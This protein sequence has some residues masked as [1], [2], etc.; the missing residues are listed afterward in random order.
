MS[1]RRRIV[2]T[3][4]LSKESIEWLRVRADVVQCGSSDAGFAAAL[5]SAHGLIVRTYTHVDEAMLSG[6]PYLRVV[7]R[8]G[9]G[10]DNIDV[11]ACGRRSIAV[12]NTP[13]AN[14]QAVV[15]YVTSLVTS[16]LRPQ[17]P[18]VTSALST[19]EWSSA[20][21]AA[22]APRQMSECS[23]GILGLGHIGQRIA[24][25][26]QAIG[27]NTR[28]CDVADIPE[29]QR[30]GATPVDLDTVLRTSDVLTIHV[31]GRPDNHHFLTPALLNLLPQDVVLLNTSRGFIMRSAD[32]AAAMAARPQAI[33]LL[34]VHDVEPIPADDPL[35]SLANVT[36]L[37]HAA[38]R[39]QAAQRA[40]SWVVR[41]VW[42]LIDNGVDT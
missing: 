30:F 27:F 24:Q 18:A 42:A 36:L 1:D 28:Y 13:A 41:D 7:G 39:T 3:E 5:Q 35:L 33:A 10:I 6:A 38:S 2:V 20:R 12:V 29:T 26:A 8:A 34:D 4:P 16:T 11:D 14:R 15:E 23:L 17:P 22:I 25:V 31:D 19:Q 37:P 21:R 9:T 40:M 32:L